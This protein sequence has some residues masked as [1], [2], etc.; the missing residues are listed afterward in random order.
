MERLPIP[1]S[2]NGSWGQIL[3]GY[4]EVEHESDGTLKIRTDGTLSAKANDSDVVHLFGNE[5][6]SGTKTF[7]SSPVV[8]TPSSGTQAANKSY[9]DTT[10]AAGTPD[11]DAVTKG[12]LQLAG[13]LSG[14]ATA[15]TVAAGAIDNAKIAPL[16]NIDQTKLNLAITNTQVA[17]G[18]A[19]AQSKLDLDTD[20]TTIAGLSPSNDDIIQRKAGAWT[21]RTMAQLRTDL[22]IPYSKSVAIESPTSSEN[23][24]LFHADAAITITKLHVVLRGSSPS[25]TFQLSHGADRSDVGAA[26][27]GGNQ[28]LTGAASTTT[29]TEYTSF[30]DA[31]LAADEMIWVTTSAVSGTVDEVALTIYYTVN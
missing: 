20:L 15:P 5:A 3:N 22:S 17:V 29:G 31:T 25:I 30:S 10:A 21:N 28:T 6:V 18:A 23:I 13:D 16:A 19:I 4:L 1:G 27:F 8:P 7:L 14:T 24:T 2:D 26:L 11:A 9:V 12:K